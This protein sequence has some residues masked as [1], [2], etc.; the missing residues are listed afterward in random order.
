VAYSEVRTRPP[1]G[2]IENREKLGLEMLPNHSLGTSGHTAT[3]TR[4]GTWRSE[5]RQLPHT[6]PS[7]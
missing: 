7:R 3:C 5:T 6:P 4:R 1:G 2:A